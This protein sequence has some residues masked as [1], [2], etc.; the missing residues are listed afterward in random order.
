MAG[1]GHACNERR[2]TMPLTS[3]LVLAGII[4]AFGAFAVMLA[5]AEYQTRHL[6]RDQHPVRVPDAK[7]D[8]HWKMA[9]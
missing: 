3:I 2:R 7:P 5:W 6:H 8:E 4:A 9:A 1:D